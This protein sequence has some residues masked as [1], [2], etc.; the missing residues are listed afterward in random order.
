MPGTPTEISSSIW[1][2]VAEDRNCWEFSDGPTPP[3]P[4]SPWHEA[5]VTDHVCSPEV[6]SAWSWLLRSSSRL[7]GSTSR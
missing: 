6:A 7:V 2:L 1:A 3:S 4:F 5:Q